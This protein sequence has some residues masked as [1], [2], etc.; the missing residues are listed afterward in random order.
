MLLSFPE[1]LIHF[2]T[3][4][5]S[6]RYPIPDVQGVPLSP[7]HRPH[8]MRGMDTLPVWITHLAYSTSVQQVAL[9]PQFLVPGA[10]LE[11]PEKEVVSLCSAMLEISSASLG[12]QEAAIENH[13][14][15]SRRSEEAHICGYSKR[16]K[17]S[18]T[19]PEATKSALL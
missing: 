8:L 3:L 13:N 19:L 14:S 10:F 18:H 11:L 5:I 15:R 17:D 4:N 2:R 7:P 12:Q 1:Y 6:T 16:S 9:T